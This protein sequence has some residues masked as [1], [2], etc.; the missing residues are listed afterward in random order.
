MANVGTI[1]LGMSTAAAAVVVVPVVVSSLAVVAVVDVVFL[2]NNLDNRLPEDGAVAV[3]AAF[4]V[5]NVGGAVDDDDVVV[6]FCDCC[7]GPYC[8]E[9]LTVHIEALPLVSI[10]VIIVPDASIDTE[11]MDAIFSGFVVTYHP[12]V[13]DTPLSD[14]R[15]FVEWDVVWVLLLLLFNVS[16]IVV[17]VVVVVL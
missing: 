6:E 9:Y 16:L 4:G 11:T 17:V 1:R 14:D 7:S 3:V 12:I 5:V 8:I 15:V 13:S 2:Q 10:A